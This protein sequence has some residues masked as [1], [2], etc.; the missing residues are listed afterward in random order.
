MYLQRVDPA[1]P[2]MLVRTSWAAVAVAF[3]VATGVSLRTDLSP[4]VAVAALIASA[5]LV[6]VLQQTLP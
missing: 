6:G 2:D 4:P 5:A 3:G 1:V